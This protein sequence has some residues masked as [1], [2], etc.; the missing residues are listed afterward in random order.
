MEDWRD[1]KG[2]KPGPHP[3]PNHTWNT[4]PE[5]YDFD[6]YDDEEWLAYKS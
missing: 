5:M 1:G 4:K 2:K 3:D 6:D